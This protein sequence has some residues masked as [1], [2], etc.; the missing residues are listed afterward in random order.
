MGGVGSTVKEMFNLN[1]PPEVED[2][3]VRMVMLMKDNKPICR[4]RCVNLPHEV[5]NRWSITEFRPSQLCQQLALPQC[6]MHPEPENSHQR[7]EWKTFLHFLSKYKKVA[8]V[9]CGDFHFYLLA[10]ED[11]PKSTHV[12]VMYEMQMPPPE[13][14]KKTNI[15][16]DESAMKNLTGKFCQKVNGIPK[17]PFPSKRVSDYEDHNNCQ[18]GEEVADNVCST[19]LG[20]HSLHREKGTCHTM[21]DCRTSRFHRSSFERS[22]NTSYPLS[23]VDVLPKNF[24][25]TDPSYLRTLGQTHAGWIF[26]AIAELVDNSRDANAIRLDLFVECL[27]F[28]KAGK[29]VPVLSV[30]DNGHGMSHNEIMRMLSFGH[31]Q[32]EEDQDKIGRFGIGFK[33]GAMKLGRDV[34]V[35]TQTST[36]RSVALL[37]QSYNA[38]K[39]ILEVPIVTY[40][41]QGSFM[42][43]D[44]SIQ[45]EEC[46][47]SNFSAVKEFSPFNEYFIGE[48][49]SLFGETGTGTQVYIWNLDEWGSNYSLEW[50]DVNSSDNTQ[51]SQGDILIRSRRVRSRPG[52]LSQKVP[53]DYS[54]QSYLEVI[55]LN[56]RMQ[57]YVQGSLV[58]SRPLAKCLN[59]TVRVSG[60]IMGRGI[61][62]T[63]G[64]SKVEWERMNC[65]IFLYWHGRLIEAY[66]RVGGQVHNADMGRGVIGVIDVTSIMDSG[67]DGVLV[68]NNK[69]G[70]Q[71]S[72]VYAKLE[73]WLGAKADEY[74]DNNFDNIDVKK[75]DDRYNPDHEWVQ[76]NKCR[77]W[78]ILP[79]DFDSKSLPPEWFCFMPPFNG[80]CQSLEEQVE[81]GVI[82]ISTRR[83]H[84][85]VGQSNTEHGEHLAKKNKSSLNQHQSEQYS[86]GRHPKAQKFPED[87]SEDY[88][89]HTGDVISQLNW[90]RPRKGQRRRVGRSS[91]GR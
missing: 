63:L 11:F 71:D 14:C 88:S 16:S 43:V 22:T 57:I 37:S 55:F 6:M 72:E 13:S 19:S 2:G 12:V 90:K 18:L 39:E 33:T 75:R 42:E 9:N 23:N 86:G 34:L 82:T 15:T 50:I 65:G 41:K 49:F 46:V 40:S 7:K 89:S 84:Y 51:Q 56:P 5:P 29:K 80:K 77:K 73:H 10:S 87:G 59:K 79:T 35:L 3:H 44:F 21:D 54:L 28:K 85:E 47:V 62:L 45:S 31:K 38:N 83:S 70:F 58:K 52:Q 48:K 20:M 17:P 36:S 66:K 67:P 53:L 8:T 26:G 76:C 61:Q 32:P 27:Y 64:R 81:Q 74:W 24:V 30:V 91:H 1:E 60:E 78:R 69:Q 25:R 4:T 68:L